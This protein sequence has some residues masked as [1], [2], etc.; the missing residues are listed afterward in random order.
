[1]YLWIFQFYFCFISFLVSY[2]CGRK[3]LF[4]C[5]IFAWIFIIYLPCI[6]VCE[7]EGAN[8]F[9]SFCRLVSAGK[10]FFL[11]VPWTDE[12]TS[13]VTVDLDWSTLMWLL[14]GLQMVCGRQHCSQWLK[15]SSIYPVWCLST[16]GCLPVLAQEGWS[17]DEV[18][19]QGLHFD[20]QM[21]PRVQMGVV[22]TLSLRLPLGHWAV[23]LEEQDCTFCH[24]PEQAR[25][26][27]DL[28]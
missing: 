10:D 22:P 21:L 5:S 16:L 28:D 24:L 19:L 8:T 18:L 9:S 4:G 26:P 12:I 23:C 27:P 13:A 7:F 3:Y 15:L 17:W 11:S 1:M 14:Q 6:D 25:L 20:L 2:H